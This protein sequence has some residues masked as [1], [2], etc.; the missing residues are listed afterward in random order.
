MGQFLNKRK[1][2]N[3]DL[4]LAALTVDANATVLTSDL[5][6]QYFEALPSE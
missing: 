6:I 2:W 5:S 4:W 1:I 3:L